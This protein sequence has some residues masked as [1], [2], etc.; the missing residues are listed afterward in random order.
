MKIIA[1]KHRGAK[2]ISPNS[3][4]VRPT[5]SKLRAAMFNVLI[6][7]GAIENSKVLDLCCGT[8]ALGLEALSRGASSVLF[9]DNNVNSLKLV[10]ANITHL[11]E[12][13]N[14]K[15]LRL[16]AVDLPMAEES[17]DLVFFDPP[18]LSKIVN[19]CLK[20]LVEQKWLNNGALIAIEIS[21][22][23]NVIYDHNFFAEIRSKIYGNSKFILLEFKK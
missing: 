5:S 2:L 11:K 12:E 6:N 4:E 19:L 9:A 21:K 20:L 8:G 23:E 22:R 15:I 17:F 14:A 1:G 7:F 10:W 18:Y 3:L 16:N 13:N